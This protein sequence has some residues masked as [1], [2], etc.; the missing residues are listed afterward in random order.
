MAEQRRNP[1][2]LFNL[3]HLLSKAIPEL[4]GSGFYV[5]ERFTVVSG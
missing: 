1:A 4:V 5:C 3:E 2:P